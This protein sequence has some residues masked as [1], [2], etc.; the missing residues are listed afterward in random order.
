M[1]KGGS[2]GLSSPTA[3]SSAHTP[4]SQQSAQKPA[5]SWSSRRSNQLSAFLKKREMPEQRQQI[6]ATPLLIRGR[7]RFSHRRKQKRQPR[8]VYD[9]GRYGAEPDGGFKAPRM[10][11]DL[12]I[13]MPTRRTVSRDRPAPRATRRKY[14]KYWALSN[15]QRM[16]VGMY[17]KKPTAVSLQLRSE[18]FNCTINAAR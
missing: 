2:R 6:I 14:G 16:V 17:I 11:V 4:G 12:T 3:T 10:Q 15:I 13:A 7:P 5:V 1:S 9:V 8:H 18:P